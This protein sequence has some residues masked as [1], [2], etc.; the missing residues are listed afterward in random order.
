MKAFLIILLLPFTALAQSQKDYDHVMASFKKAYNRHRADKVCDLFP[1][2]TRVKVAKVWNNREMDKLYNDYGKIVSY[3]YLGRDKTDPDNV[4]VY[5]A[6]FQKKT[7]P[8]SLSLDKDKNLENFR[9]DTHSD[10]I[11]EMMKKEQ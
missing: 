7:I 6:V 2:E 1:R 5:K 3:K 11:D 10:E 4:T 9:L 8:M